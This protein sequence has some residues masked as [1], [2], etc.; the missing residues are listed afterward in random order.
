MKLATQTSCCSSYFGNKKAI[1]IIQEAGFDS[2]DFSMFCMSSE[3]SVLNTDEYKNF[4]KDLKKYADEIGIIFTQAHAPFSFTIS[5]GEDYFLNMAKQKIIRAF[6]I[7]SILEI[8]VMVVHPLQFRPYYKKKNRKYFNELNVKYYE[9]YL[10]YCEKYGVKIACENIWQTKGKGKREHI[11]SGACSDPLEFN[12]LIDTVN[13]KY[14][15]GCLDIGHCGLTGRNAADCIRTIGHDRLKALHVH[16]NDNISDLHY[17][18]GYGKTDWDEVAKALAEIDYDGNITFE[19]DEFLI[20]FENDPE[21]ALQATKVME[22][23]GRNL[24]NKIEE[25]KK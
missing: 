22:K 11:I 20:P 9:D 4:A 15:V 10:Y 6:E 25:Y 2:V 18:P 21:N 8:P 12:K 1:S 23:I 5:K 19:A 7:A 24:I 13:S 14:F 17:P 3:D 16:D